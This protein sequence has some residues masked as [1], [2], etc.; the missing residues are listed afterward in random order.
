MEKGFV[1]VLV[2]LIILAT[3]NFQLFL[4]L[5]ALFF[6]GLSIF[7]SIKKITEKCKNEYKRDVLISFSITVLL[8]TWLVI[9][10]VICFGGSTFV[11][12]NTGFLYVWTI[13]PLLS[14]GITIAF[15]I[16]FLYMKAKQNKAYQI[17]STLLKEIEM[18]EELSVKAN[19]FF[20][21]YAQSSHIVNLLNLLDETTDIENKYVQS[22]YT[23]FYL[24]FTFL[25]N[26]KICT[27]ISTDNK[28]ALN[29]FLLSTNT[30]IKRKNITKIHSQI[31]TMS[32]D[33]LI[34]C[35]DNCK[36]NANLLIEEF[37]KFANS[38]RK[39]ISRN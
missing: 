25:Y 7:Y 23:D 32:D 30:V 27:Y 35:W 4:A 39:K 31:D 3:L 15:F 9:F 16:R 13:V 22:K 2:I 24:K 26:N 36:G 19:A 5:A 11:L 29:H 37:E 1:T 8:L 21:S 38:K 18:L 12:V 28:K 20:N 6:C 34:C 14:L 10:G 33:E 17:K